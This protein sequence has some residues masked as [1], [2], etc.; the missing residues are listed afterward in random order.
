MR[1]DRVA[2]AG[3]PP[4]VA[5]AVAARGASQALPVAADIATPDGRRS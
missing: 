4:D 3:V 2:V 1:V 5:P